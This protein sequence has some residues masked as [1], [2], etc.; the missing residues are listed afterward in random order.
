[1][2]SHG[3]LTGRL[4]P[5]DFRQSPW[6]SQH[7]ELLATQELRTLAS[8]SSSPLRCF[9]V[10]RGQYLTGRMVRSQPWF[11]RGQQLGLAMNQV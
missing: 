8:C 4:P 9:R 1:M 7:P 3:H 2:V 10:F 5:N 11:E 6:V